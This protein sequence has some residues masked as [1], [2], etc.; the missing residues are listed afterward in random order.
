MG[1]ELGYVLG[2][3]YVPGMDIMGMMGLGYDGVLGLGLGYG[4]EMKV[5]VIR[6]W[7]ID[8]AWGW[9]KWDWVRDKL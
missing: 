4:L 7:G 1:L 9:R 6:G 5:V 2:M 8:W 3:A